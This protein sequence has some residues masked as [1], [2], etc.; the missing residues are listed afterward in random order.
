MSY[1]VVTNIRLASIWEAFS[2][3]SNMHKVLHLYFL[4]VDKV[5]I[6]LVHKRKMCNYEI[7]L[8][9]NAVAREGGRNILHGCVQHISVEVFMMD[10]MSVYL[11]WCMRSSNINICD[12]IKETLNF[13]SWI[14]YPRLSGHRYPS[15]LWK[16]FPS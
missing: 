5:I 1:L 11:V 2:P 14:K 16:H 6:M 10:L 13:L 3:I 4:N 12:A 8:Q 7:I 15:L 9:R